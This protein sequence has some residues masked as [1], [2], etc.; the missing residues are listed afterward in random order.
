MKGDMDRLH[1]C[2][3]QDKTMKLDIG[4]IEIH[5]KEKV[6]FVLLRQLMVLL[7]EDVVEVEEQ[8]IEEY[9]LLE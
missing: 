2:L 8:D 3:P 5:E 7:V 1:L 6:V 9:G 4:S